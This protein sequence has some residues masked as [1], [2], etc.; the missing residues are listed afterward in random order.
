MPELLLFLIGLVYS[1][2]AGAGAL[3]VLKARSSVRRTNEPTA[4][5]RSERSA[6]APSS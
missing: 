4:A 5:P 6:A 2:I 3:F 1:G